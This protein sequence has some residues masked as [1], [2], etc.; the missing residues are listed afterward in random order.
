MGYRSYEQLDKETKYQDLKPIVVKT[1]RTDSRITPQEHFE[2]LL[3][4]SLASGETSSL[5]CKPNTPEARLAELAIRAMGKGQEYPVALNRCGEEGKNT[6]TNKSKFIVEELKYPGSDIEQ[7][8]V[9][10]VGQ[11]VYV[12]SFNNDKKLV[13]EA[14]CGEDGWTNRESK[15]SAAVV[16][17][18]RDQNFLEPLIPSNRNTYS[19]SSRRFLP[20]PLQSSDDEVAF[21]LS[22]VQLDKKAIEIVRKNLAQAAV[23]P[24][25]IQG[26]GGYVAIPEPV[27]WAS[28][29][30]EKWLI[31][32]A[33]KHQNHLPILSEDLF[34][35]QATEEFR[36]QG[37]MGDWWQDGCLSPVPIVQRYI[38]Q[39]GENLVEA[40]NYVRMMIDSPQHRAVEAACTK[41]ALASAW[42]LQH[43]SDVLPPMVCTGKGREFVSELA[44]GQN[45]GEGRLPQTIVSMKSSPAGLTISE[46]LW[47]GNAL[48]IANL[49]LS[50][51]VAPPSAVST[52]KV[53]D[54]VLINAKADLRKATD[55]QRPPK[56]KQYSGYLSKGISGV[57]DLIKV[58]NAV[59]NVKKA[60]KDYADSS[61]SD[62]GPWY[63]RSREELT[64]INAYTDPAATVTNNLKDFLKGKP[65]LVA[66][67][68][69]GFLVLATALGDAHAMGSIG[70]TAYKDKP[71][72]SVLAAGIGTIGVGFS[73]TTGLAFLA[74]TS[75]A[76]TGSAA[77]YLVFALNPY[78]LAAAVV[79]ILIGKLFSGGK[80]ANAYEQFLWRC[81]FGKK[82][83]Q[84]INPSCKWSQ[85]YLG[86]LRRDDELKTVIGM[87]CA[88]SVKLLFTGLELK[89]TPGY[90]PEGS[91]FEVAIDFEHFTYV[92]GGISVASKKD[93][94]TDTFRLEEIKNGGTNTQDRRHRDNDAGITYSQKFQVKDGR[95][96]S[97][98]IVPDK[99]I[100]IHQAWIRLI[101]GKYRIQVP[102]EEKMPT[103]IIWLRVRTNEEFNSFD[104]SKYKSSS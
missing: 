14:L 96:E 63:W 47:R 34:I 50:V 58:S 6:I 69:T 51:F 97:I 104:V 39:N 87:L 80:K 27:E 91:Y 2:A 10:P 32:K 54:Q 33:D 62:K 57:L 22:P 79:M 31:P 8:V 86:T 70:G 19:A 49:F 92:P 30:N 81:R 55:V 88:F 71:V 37:S 56:I 85:E 68:L 38:Q 52:P 36:Q 101:A 93:G 83:G 44:H 21:F 41:D 102:P 15:E 84:Y 24:G 11:F 7:H 95:V 65:G 4:G 53:S 75:T 17:F 66:S 100:R 25:L 29:A 3:G 73:A 5:D 23:K 16:W 48:T 42:I 61:S 78:F 90:L 76:V 40:S 20:N 1:R 60:N 67:R 13:L 98:T 46:D 35:A 99:G 26:L 64:L 103:K 43:W 82:H 72:T 28:Q 89:I 12:F 59:K 45:A 74:A 9:S 77:S 94:R 18:Y